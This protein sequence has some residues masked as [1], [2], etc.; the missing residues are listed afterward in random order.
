MRNSDYASVRLCR[1]PNPGET[2]ALADHMAT[3]LSHAIAG[4][5]RP[6]DATSSLGWRYRES[7]IGSPTSTI[8]SLLIPLNRGGFS[9]VVNTHHSPS[10]ERA[11]WLTAHEIGH[12]FFYAPGSP[13]RRIVPVTADEEAFCDAFA[14]RLLWAAR[15]S[16]GTKVDAA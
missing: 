5:R 2:A 16:H 1:V 10:R 13:P 14:H 8:E 6:E 12:S 3:V 11:M 4:S 7:P 15:R 9:V